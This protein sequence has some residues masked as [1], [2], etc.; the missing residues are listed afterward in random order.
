VK[1]VEEE[2]LKDPVEGV[3][4][5]EGNRSDGVAVIGIMQCEKLSAMREAA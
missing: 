2:G 3:D 5:A 1:G 4:A